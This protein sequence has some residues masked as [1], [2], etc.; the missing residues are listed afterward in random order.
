MQNSCF[1]FFC[2]SQPWTDIKLLKNLWWEFSGSDKFCATQNAQMLHLSGIVQRTISKHD[3]R[4]QKAEKNWN[5]AQHANYLRTIIVCIY[6]LEFCFYWPYTFTLPKFLQALRILLTPWDRIL[7]LFLHC[8]LL[9]RKS[10][11]PCGVF[12]ENMFSLKTSAFIMLYL[13]P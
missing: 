10:R 2:C 8:V 5:W 9:R 4:N 3:M 1:F 12:P 6:I 13:P 7:H 11:W